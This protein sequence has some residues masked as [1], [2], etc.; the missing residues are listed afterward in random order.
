[1]TTAPVP[2]AVH[3]TRGGKRWHADPNCRALEAGRMLWDTDDN[4]LYPV[5]EVSAEL[6]ADLKRKPCRTCAPEA[7]K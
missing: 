7:S 1:M 4:F 5:R 2:A 3:L 6:A